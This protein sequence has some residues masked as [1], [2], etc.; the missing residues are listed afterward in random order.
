MFDAPGLE[1]KKIHITHEY[2]KSQIE[3]SSLRKAI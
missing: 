3:R 2:A 1:A